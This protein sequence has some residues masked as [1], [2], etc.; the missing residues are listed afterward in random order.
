MA[1]DH[2][3]DVDGRECVADRIE[4]AVQNYAPAEHPLLTG[5]P[6]NIH[7]KTVAPAGS[8]TARSL[9]GDEAAGEGGKRLRVQGAEVRGGIGATG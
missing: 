1:I 8:R 3:A 9:A 5:M 4:N 7:G 6:G 2:G